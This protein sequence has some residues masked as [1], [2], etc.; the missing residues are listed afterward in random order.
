MDPAVGLVNAYLELSGYFVLTEL[1]VR[2]ADQ[3]GYHDVTD[4]DIIAVR[5]PHQAP[6]D[7]RSLS[8]PLDVFLGVDAALDGYDDG[9]DVVIGEV[10]EA[11]AHLNPAL[12]RVETIAFAL[13]RIGCCPEEHIDAEG[14]IIAHDGSADFAYPGR[15]PCRVRIVAFAGYGSGI[16]RGIRTI[17]LGHCSQFIAMRLHEGRDVLAGVQFKDPTLGLFALEEKLAQ[18]VIAEN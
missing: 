18:H 8:R 14:Q 12:R 17:T 1:P 5:F 6:R 3:H 16:D 13:R 7:A 4:L 2:A 11:R 15:L 9:I 10:K